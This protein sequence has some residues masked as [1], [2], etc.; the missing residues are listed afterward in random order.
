MS[1]VIKGFDM[2]ISCERCP[3]CYDY[4]HCSI[5]NYLQM[6]LY[7]R[8]PNCPLI[9]IPTPHGRLIDADALKYTLKECCIDGDEEAQRWYDIMGIDDGI[10]DYTIAILEA[11]E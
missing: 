1:V 7:N 9:E 6:F 5:N 8:H 11:E 4:L 2:P 3:L 10:D